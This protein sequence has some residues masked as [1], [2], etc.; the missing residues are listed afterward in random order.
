MPHLHPREPYGNTISYGPTVFLAVNVEHELLEQMRDLQLRIYRLF[1]DR[2]RKEG[3]SL[4]QLKLLGL[5]SRAG[6]IRST[7]IA[8]ALGQAPRTVTEAV[9]GLERDGLVIRRPDD[10]DRRV[11]RISLTEAG[12]AVVRDVAPYREAFAAEF[13]AALSAQDRADLLRLFKLLNDRIIEMGAPS[14]FG[15]SAL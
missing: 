15:D 11:K 5:V 12:H 14:A 1:N 2:V 6:S 3:A 7:D 8:D 10:R 4:A 13:F 9:D